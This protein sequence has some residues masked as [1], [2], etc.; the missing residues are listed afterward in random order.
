MHCHILGIGGTFMGSLAQIAKAF[1]HTITGCDA[2]IYSPMKEQLQN[3]NIAWSEGYQADD[4]KLKPDI[5]I[6]G[7]AIKRGNPLMEKILNENLPF[8]SGPQ[9]LFEN[10]LQKKHVLAVAGTH[11]KT[12][13]SAMLA[14]ILEENGF[15]PSFLI[16][17][18]PQ[19]FGVS[20]RLTDSPFFVIEADEYDTA[21]FDK[22]S[23]F[24]HYHPKT[25][26]L[27]NLEFDHADIF[28]NLN[29]I[30][31]QFHHLVR[32]LAQNAQI[33]VNAKSDALSRVLKRGVFSALRYFGD[34]FVM[35]GDDA[36]GEIILKEKGKTLCQGHWELLGEH[37]RQNATAAILAAMHVGISPEKAFA[38][39][40][41]FHNVKRRLELKDNIAGIAVY[42]D[43][44][45]HPS[46]IA[47]TIAGLRR[48]VGKSR[49]LAVFEPRSNTMK[50]GTMRAALPDSLKDADLI[51][52][53]A[54]GLEWN[55]EESLKPLGEKSFVFKDLDALIAKIT[56]LAKP[57]DSVLVMSNGS[58]EGIHEKLLEKLKNPR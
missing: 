53:Y 19:N 14:W 21:F 43:F 5:F 16:G 22:R 2:A 44:A 45:H 17:G 18:V 47:T 56:E 7:N 24:V 31:T 48:K 8:I 10:I 52:C 49:I 41:T 40:K 57:S 28:E 34:D 23:K 38:A 27:N 25:L 4:L 15:N 1:G 12:T 20:A 32:M 42:D 26:I 30:E 36:K 39:L 37:N 6:I 33:V 51:F 9:W 46:A 50:L 55:A 13:T 11:G 3:A 54:K 35:L 29:A 58:F